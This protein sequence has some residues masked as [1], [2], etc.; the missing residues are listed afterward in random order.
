[1]CRSVAYV[2][3]GFASQNCFSLFSGMCSL[4]WLLT[5]IF[6]LNQVRQEKDGKVSANICTTTQAH[7][8]SAGIPIISWPWLQFLFCFLN[9]F[10]LSL[11]LKLQYWSAFRVSEP[12]NRIKL[13]LWHLSEKI[14]NDARIVVECKDFWVWFQRVWCIHRSQ[15]EGQGVRGICGWA[16]V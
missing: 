16:T 1:M 6:K 10:C 2:H 11:S 14:I 7:E 9:A 12:S 3:H 8:D 13:R 5:E 4:F 15:S